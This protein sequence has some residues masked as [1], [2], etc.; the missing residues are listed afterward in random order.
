MP[1][2]PVTVCLEL[3]VAFVTCFRHTVQPGACP[4]H[5]HS[6]GE[7]VWHRRGSGECHLASGETS[8]FGPNTVHWFPPKVLHRQE[9]L[10]A[11]EDWCLHLNLGPELPDFWRRCVRWMPDQAGGCGT[12]VWEALLRVGTLQADRLGAREHHRGV[13]DLRSRL[14][15]AALMESAAAQESQ[16]YGRGHAGLAADFIEEHFDRIE[17]MAEVA[18]AVDV[19]YDHL[20]HLFRQEMGMSL[21]QYL[22]RVR[23]IRSEQLVR[24]TAATLREIALSCGFA[25]ERYFSTCFAD[26]YG[27]P[28]GEYRRQQ[29]GRP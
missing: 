15:L 29:S 26:H 12:E 1:A 2:D 24:H 14:V 22:R 3:P 17:S 9:N 23:V 19:G 21:A 18:A 25:N 27:R 28:P 10:E 7:L 5:K 16:A 20:R 6:Y 8:H 11:G 4:H 13:A